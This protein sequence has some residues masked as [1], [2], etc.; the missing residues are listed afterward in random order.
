MTTIAIN[1][2]GGLMNSFPHDPVKPDLGIL[3]DLV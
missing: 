1:V 3:L 2:R